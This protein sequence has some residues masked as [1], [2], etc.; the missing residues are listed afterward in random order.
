MIIMFLLFVEGRRAGPPF[1]GPRMGSGSFELVKSRTN[2]AIWGDTLSNRTFVRGLGKGEGGGNCCAVILTQS[3]S[4]RKE[5][6][7]QE[8]L[9]LNDEIVAYRDHNHSSCL[10]LSI[11]QSPIAKL[12]F[13]HSSSLGE[14]DSQQRLLDLGGSNPLLQILEEIL[15]AFEVLS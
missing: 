10:L 13:E 12:V 15:V 14:V 7:G 6:L 11:L 5:I 3:G 2:G 4:N 8:I 9:G 1:S